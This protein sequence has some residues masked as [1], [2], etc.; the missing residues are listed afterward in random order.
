[1]KKIQDME[2]NKVWREGIVLK[3][4]A[5]LIDGQTFV[6]PTFENFRPHIEYLNLGGKHVGVDTSRNSKSLVDTDGKPQWQ[7]D[8]EQKEIA[9]EESG[10]II[11]KHHGGQSKPEKDARGDLLEEAFGTR[12]WKR[13][14]TLARKMIERGRNALWLKLEGVEYNF[15]PPEPDLD[16]DIPYEEGAEQDSEKA[17]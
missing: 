7:Y 11:K 14:E 12:S 6:N 4:R 3:D 15:A 13:V 8:K 17:A 2:T 16:D 10:E 5:D 9:L 1:M